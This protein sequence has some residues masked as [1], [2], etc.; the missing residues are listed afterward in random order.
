MSNRMLDDHLPLPVGQPARLQRMRQERVAHLGADLQARGH[1]ALER[2]APAATV[3]IGQ[4]AAQPQEIRGEN[5]LRV[6][7][8][9]KGPHARQIRVIVQRRVVR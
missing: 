7:K 4:P 3:I 1:R 8:V 9:Y 2:L 5:R 6:R